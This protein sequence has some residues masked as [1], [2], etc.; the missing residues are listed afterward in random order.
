M[1]FKKVFGKWIKLGVVWQLTN[2]Q[3]RTTICRLFKDVATTLS[4]MSFW[5]SFLALFVFFFFLNYAVL[6]QCMNMCWQKRRTSPTHGHPDPEFGRGKILGRKPE[7]AAS[8]AKLEKTFVHSIEIIHI[9][10]F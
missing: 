6:Q 7:V 5:S 2:L 8:T 10:V 1:Q 9:Y 3:V 4:P